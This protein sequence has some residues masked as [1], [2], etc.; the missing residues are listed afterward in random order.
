MKQTCETCACYNDGECLIHFTQPAKANAKDPACE[1]YALAMTEFK[2]A[3]VDSLEK[4]RRKHPDFIPLPPFHWGNQLLYEARQYKWKVQDGKGELQ[5]VLLS[6]CYE[7]MS[8]LAVGDFDHA[9]EEAGDVMAV[10]Y[11]ALNG[12]GKQEENK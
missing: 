9:L 3:L 12:D 1:D 4:A 6:E 8:A 7:F 11:R 10:L 2:W 5:E